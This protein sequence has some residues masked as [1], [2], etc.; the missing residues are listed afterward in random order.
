MFNEWEYTLLDAY[1]LIARGGAPV[2]QSVRADNG[3]Q[4]VS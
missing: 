3:L 4:S 1:L 2:V